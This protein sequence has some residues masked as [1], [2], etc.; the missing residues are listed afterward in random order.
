M[1]LASGHPAVDRYL[2]EGYA[3]VRGMSS[4][5][6]AAICGHV[7]RRQT[8][9]GIAGDVAEI[10][11][12]EGRFFIALGLALAEG[13]HAYG[14]DTFDW[15][16][17]G[18]LARLHGHC[19]ANGL[20]GDRYTAIERST[21]GLSPAEFSRLTGGK[22]LRFV[23]IDGEHSHEA[24]SHDLALAHAALHPDGILCL[25][26]MLHPVYPFLVATVQHYLAAHPEMRL[27][28]ILDRED[29]VAAAKF[30]LCRKEAVPLYEADLMQSFPQAHLV[31]GGDALGHHCVV[32]TPQPRLA[33]V[34]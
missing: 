9:L 12:F 5:F 1:S 25:D 24:L 30:L 2:A 19:A 3:G 13:E 21:A 34:D 18:V 23:H 31:L 20:D 15:P 27:M 8:A 10:G 7:L 28:A 33:A 6:A 22:A 17:D 14:F 29:V 32:L 4:R 16:N 26:D 11:T